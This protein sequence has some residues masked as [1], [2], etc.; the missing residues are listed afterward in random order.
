MLDKP[1]AYVL[2]EGMYVLGKC[3]T[4]NFNLL[5]FPLPQG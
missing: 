5:D 3:S 1:C 2:A 4:L